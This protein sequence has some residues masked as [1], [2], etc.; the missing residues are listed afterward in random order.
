MKITTM[1]AKLEIQERKEGAVTILNLVGSLDGHTFIQM[2]SAMKALVDE[3][4]K[5]FVIELPDLSYIASA[6]I[7]V[8]INVQQTVAGDGGGLI[9]VNPSPTVREVFDILG[10]QAL[11]QIHDETAPALEAAERLGG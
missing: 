10:L 1:A 2:E 5:I 8:F 7:G 9:L 6:G 4:N 3:G 11:F